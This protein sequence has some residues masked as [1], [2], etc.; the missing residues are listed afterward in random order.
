MLRCSTK[1]AVV[2]YFL[3]WALVVHA[4][5]KTCKTPGD[6]DSDAV[7]EEVK[8]ALTA[9]IRGDNEERSR[10]LRSAWQ[11]HPESPEVNWHLTRVRAEKEWVP[12][13]EVTSQAA[14][15]PNLAK[16]RQIREK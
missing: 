11:S 10:L 9:E 2:G 1:A 12:L 8:K 15:D 3:N 13:A 16:Y 5:D 4:A 6:K 14:G 7:T